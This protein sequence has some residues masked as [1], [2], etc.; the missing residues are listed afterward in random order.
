MTILNT[1]NKLHTVVAQ[2]LIQIVNQHLGIIGFQVSAIV[3]DDSSVL[4]SDD[5]ATNRKVIITH[6]ITD[7]SGF[8]WT[9]TFIHFVQVVTHDGSVCHFT[10]WRKS[11]GH[12]A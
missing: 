9:T 2:V 6:F 4:Q 11:F 5:I 8:E 1:S 7:R 10:S 3:R 12:R